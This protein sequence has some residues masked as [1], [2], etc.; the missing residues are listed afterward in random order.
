MSINNHKRS[1]RRTVV[2]LR[3]EGEPSFQ[4]SPSNFPS[5]LHSPPV[6]RRWP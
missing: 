5:F 6:G 4:G 2:D 3:L 1:V